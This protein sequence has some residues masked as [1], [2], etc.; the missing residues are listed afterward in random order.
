MAPELFWM[1]ATAVMTGLLWVPYI[2][3]FIGERGLVGA[4][5]RRKGDEV[6]AADWAQRAQ[7]AH[8]NAVEN[9]VVFAPLALGVALTGAGTALTALAAAAYFWLRLAHFVVYTAGIPVVRTLLFAGGVVCQLILG[10][11]LITGG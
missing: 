4:L 1:A 8:R 3:S 7:W 9:L 2:L 6:G 11:A 5:T 10:I